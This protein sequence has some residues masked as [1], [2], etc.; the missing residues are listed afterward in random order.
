MKI[1][2]ILDKVRKDPECKVFPPAGLPALSVG[3]V[4][5]PDLRAFYE[6]CGGVELFGEEEYSA[7]VVG[8]KELVSSNLDILGEPNPDDITDSWYI[9]ARDTEDSLLQKMSIDLAPG[10]LGRCHDSFWDQY[11]AS[12]PV[13]ARSFTELLERLYASRGDHWYW[14]QPGFEEPRP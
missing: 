12:S 13:I 3:H 14:L 7:R 6:L 10:R 8:P 9:V 5:P 2:Q 4:L 11:G 1:E